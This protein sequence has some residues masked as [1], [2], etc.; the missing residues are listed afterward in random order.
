MNKINVLNF[1]AKMVFTTNKN[2]ASNAE[3]FV[4]FAHSSHVLNAKKNF[5]YLEIN[6]F[7]RK[8]L[9]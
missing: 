9:F 6:A 8:D 5:S 3:V 2:N 4:K 7:A 1:L